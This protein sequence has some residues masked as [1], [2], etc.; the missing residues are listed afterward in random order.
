MLKY[1]IDVLPALKAAGYS[2]YR[3]RHEHIFGEG[4]MSS[5]RRGNVAD[6]PVIDRLCA[7]LHCQPGDLL[8]YIPDEQPPAE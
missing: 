8:E 2:S 5:F 3:L 4:T 7:L 1:K 6:A